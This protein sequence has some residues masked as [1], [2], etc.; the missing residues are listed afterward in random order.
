[1]HATEVFDGRGPR[2][3]EPTASL[4]PLKG[5][6]AEDVRTLDPLWM[7]RRGHV[8]REPVR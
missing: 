3:G 1:M 6:S 4:S 7:A 8:I 2:F 5:D